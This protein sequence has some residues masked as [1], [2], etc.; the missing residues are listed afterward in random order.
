MSIEQNKA[1]ARRFWEMYSSGADLDSI[2]NELLAPNLVVHEAG[3]PTPEMNVADYKQFGA[4]YRAAFPDMHMTIEDQ[5]AEGDRVVSRVAFRGIHT[6]ELMGIPP[7]GKQV[8]TS[9][10][11]IDRIVDGK[12]MERWSVGDNLGLLQQLGVI[13]APGT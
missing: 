10:I 3:A 11:V 1:V 7:T 8:R 2:V 4:L 12:I 13:P 5:V 9:N 6:G